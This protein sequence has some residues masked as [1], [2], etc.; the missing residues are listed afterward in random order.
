MTEPQPENE[1]AAEAD[2][3]SASQKTRPPLRRRIREIRRRISPLRTLA[4]KR[5]QRECSGRVLSGPFA[6]LRY[7]DEILRPDL[8]PKLLGTYEKELHPWLE[9]LLARPIAH[10]INVGAAEGYYAT[11]FALRQ[12]ET[13]VLAFEMDPV[14]QRRMRVLT[15]QNGVADRVQMSGVEQ[16]FRWWMA[17]WMGLGVWL[18]ASSWWPGAAQAEEAWTRTGILTAADAEAQRLGYDVEHL[19][20]SFDFRNSQWDGHTASFGVLRD[21]PR[22][23]PKLRGHDYFAVYYAPLV[24]ELGGDLWVFVDRDSGDVITFLRGQ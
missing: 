13:R 2:S 7:L 24:K 14:E 18:L 10:I 5:I 1:P 3:T 17:G 11:G 20:V 19:S 16:A 9:E 6:G 12:P 4:W 21:L 15:E 8:L 22:G 23:I